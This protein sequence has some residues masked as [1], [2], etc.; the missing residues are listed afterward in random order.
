MFHVEHQ[1]G[2]EIASAEPVS[3]GTPGPEPLENSRNMKQIRPFQIRIDRF[4][5]REYFPVGG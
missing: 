4:S 3:R 5:R 1:G 2:H